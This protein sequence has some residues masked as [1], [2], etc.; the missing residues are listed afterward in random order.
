MKIGIIPNVRETYKNQFEY[1]IDIKLI[2][3]LGRNFPKYEII[4]LNNLQKINNKFKLI[5]FSGGNTL[6]SFDKSAKNII[7]SRLDNFYYRDAIKKNI[8]VLG[9][10]HG[11]QFIANKFNSKIVKNKQIGN[12]KIFFNNENK[13]II[14]NSY[15]NLIIKKLGKKLL[16]I[17]HAKDGS[18]EYFHTKNR[19][20]VG[21]MW[22]P[23]RY[24]N[25]KKIDRVLISN[26]LCI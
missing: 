12:H 25:F 5:I 19:K 7:R 20:V 13:N 16:P 10:C 17:A 2:D 24:K 14:V 18:V 23:E 8:S 3:I 4:I 9:I 1:S 26:L 11:A 6:I 15:H 22:H 21:I